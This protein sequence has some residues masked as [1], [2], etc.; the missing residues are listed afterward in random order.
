WKMGRS[1]LDL[2]ML[3]PGRLYTSHERR[4]PRVHRHHQEPRRYDKDKL[5][6]FSSQKPLAN[7]PRWSRPEHTPIYNYSSL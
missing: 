1:N 6:Q 5:K 2:D 3:G 4:Y 7:V